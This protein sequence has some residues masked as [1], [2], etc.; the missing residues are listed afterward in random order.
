MCAQVTWKEFRERYATISDYLI[1]RTDGS[2]M[3]S[4]PTLR[5]WLLRRRQGE[6]TRSEASPNLPF[7]TSLLPL[8]K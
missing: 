1:M 8:Q 4:H 2:V 3:F 7:Y 5:D 6:P